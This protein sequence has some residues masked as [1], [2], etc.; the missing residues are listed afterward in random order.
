MQVFI[1]NYNEAYIEKLIASG[2]QIL[3]GEVYHRPT[4]FWNN[5]E[6]RRLLSYKYFCQN[7][8]STLEELVNNMLASR[9]THL[10]PSNNPAFHN[11]P[12]CPR[13]NAEYANYGLPAEIKLRG[14]DEQ[15]RYVAWFREKY[16][17]NPAYRVDSSLLDEL[18]ERSR[19]VFGLSE[20]P[21]P[22]ALA[23]SGVIPLSEL[24][25]SELEKLID[26]LINEAEAFTQ[27]SP[28]HEALIRNEGPHAYRHSEQRNL[29]LLGVFQCRMAYNMD[30]AE[31]AVTLREFEERF[32]N[33][34]QLY[35]RAYYR[36]KYNPQGTYDGHLLEKIGFVSCRTCF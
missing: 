3:E 6:K 30:H 21:Q 1:T 35:L 32:K 26:D 18:L 27:Q 5:Q 7:P 25:L 28:G 13:A 34:L 8:R 15:V 12:D 11:A 22:L 29:F 31:V 19:L 16:S 10:L 36:C 20:K 17:E 24:L 33:P 4:P 9:D 14:I 23:N 2:K